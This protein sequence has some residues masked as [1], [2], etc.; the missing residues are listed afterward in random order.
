MLVS[1]AGAGAILVDENDQVYHQKP[2]KGTVKNSVGAG[3]SMVA[4]FVAGYL[5]T[6]GPRHFQRGLAQKTIL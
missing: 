1:M 6:E 5:E 2:A 4:G 3:D